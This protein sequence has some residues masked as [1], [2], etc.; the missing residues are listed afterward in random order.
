[1][2]RATLGAVQLSQLP[3][4]IGAVNSD[5]PT[6]AAAVN[7]AQQTLI[8]DGG[9]N[10]WVGGWM[11]VIIP[12]FQNSPY[13][14]L[15]REWSRL[16][17]LDACRTAM[18]L[19][20]PFYEFL[21]AGIGLQGKFEHGRF[22]G[23]LEGYDRG[24]FPTMIDLAPANQYLRVYVTD[25]RDLNARILFTNATDSTGSRIYS[26][27]GNNT[28][29]G[30]YMKM[31]QPFNTSSLIVTGFGGVQK[32]LTYG[33]IQ[34]FQVDATTGE[35]V[36]L[37]TYAPDELI[38]SY[39]RYYINRLPCHCAPCL[40]NNPC[41]NPQTTPLKVL[42]TGLA[43][44]EFIPATRA[45]DVLI[46]GN[47]PALIEECKANR[48]ADMDSPKAAELSRIAHT[49]A[50]KLLN[51]ELVSYVGKYNVAISFQPFGTAKLERLRI[52]MK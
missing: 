44:L 24:S 39:H 4:A 6:I 3:Q 27:D 21:W 20:N 9:E 26:Q 32:D 34:L 7:R 35:Q 15:P 45:T 25:P 10:G 17:G 29:N 5:L 22:H 36:M 50:I 37:A 18:R 42:L 23:T 52:A 16:I 43:K 48:Y 47:I 51:N 8:D 12:V 11:K 2:I 49:K 38:P 19:Q 33:D 41:A 30:F 1:M 14:T 40:P 46:I 13:I 28:V 31:A